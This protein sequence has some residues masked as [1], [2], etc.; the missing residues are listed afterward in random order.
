M[1]TIANWW[2]IA[3]KPWCTILVGASSIP[4]FYYMGWDFERS[5]AIVVAF[6]LIAELLL[7]NEKWLGL[8][9]I[10]PLEYAQKTGS[11][12]KV[13]EWDLKN[14]ASNPS[15]LDL[16]K[17]TASKSD[18]DANGWLFQKTAHRILF[19]SVLSTP[20]LESPVH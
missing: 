3:W 10:L 6:C 4:V 5:G 15:P 1:K 17:A 12:Y 13:G 7:F 8:A 18:F 19:A 9:N 16:L 14:L 11:G 2:W 20:L